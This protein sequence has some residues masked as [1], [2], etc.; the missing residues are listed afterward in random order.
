MYSLIASI[1]SDLIAIAIFSLFLENVVK[2][3]D[4]SDSDCGQYGGQGMYCGLD[5]ASEV[6]LT[7]T[8]QLVSCLCKY[9]VIVFI[10]C[11]EEVLQQEYSQ[12]PTPSKID[13]FLYMSII[14]KCI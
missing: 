7:F 12:T 9:N 4:S 10:S 14:K 11:Q 2:K 3:K 5:A 6:F 1:S 8:T 13:H